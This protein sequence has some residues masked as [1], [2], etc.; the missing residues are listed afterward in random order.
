VALD[1]DRRVA[2]EGALWTL[3]VALP[4]VW[5]VAVL[6]SDDVP[7]EESNLWLLTPV[8][9]LAGFAIGGFV[10]GR[11][12]PETPLVHAAAAGAV[13]FGVVVVFGVLRR[14]VGDDDVTVSYVVRL[15]LLAQICVST[16]L[17]GGWWA[18]RRAVHEQ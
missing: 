9:L 14:V 15:L 18:A 2:F 17:L 5:L 11:R 7:G 8:A 10:A 4:P 16:A 6:K 3:A 1:V 12:R 13:A